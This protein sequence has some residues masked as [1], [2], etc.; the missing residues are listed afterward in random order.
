MKIELVFP[1]PPYLWPVAFSWLAP[2][3]QIVCDDYSP[4]T[5]AAY[6]ELAIRDN[7]EAWGVS[8]D[9]R[10]V[11]VVTFEP[12]NPACAL[13]HF[14]FCPGWRGKARTDAAA[15]VVLGHAF[16]SGIEKV[17][18]IMPE[19]NRLAIA[20]AVRVGAKVEGLLRNHSVRDGKPLNAVAVG[21]TKE[22]FINVRTR[23]R[24]IDGR[25]IEQHQVV[26]PIDE[27]ADILG[28]ADGSPVNP[29]P[30]VH[31]SPAGDASG[32]D[33]GTSASGGD[34]ERGA[35]RLDQF[36]DGH[37][38]ATVPR[39]PRVRSERTDRASRPAD[40]TRKTKRAG[41]KRVKRGGD[42]AKSK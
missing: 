28:G 23:F 37:S 22:D 10:I 30:T 24:R 36:G 25:I 9:G 39:K 32:H 18:G 5:I 42:A 13:I 7:I 34:G 15:R 40:G 20:L 27:H 14:L 17:L 8:S 11:G 29:G 21:I 19:N 2:V 3:R 12:V 4:K 16:E 33:L 26:E 41:G 6:V 35:D 38:D 1:F 31:G